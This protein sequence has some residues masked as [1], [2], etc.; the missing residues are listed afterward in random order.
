[1][2]TKRDMKKERKLRSYRFILNSTGSQ[3]LMNCVGQKGLIAGQKKFKEQNHEFVKKIIKYEATFFRQRILVYAM[4]VEET[5]KWKVKVMKIVEDY[6]RVEGIASIIMDMS[7]DGKL[8]RYMWD[9]K[10]NKSALN[11]MNKIKYCNRSKRLM[12]RFLVSY[13]KHFE[14]ETSDRYEK[15][16]HINVQY[17]CQDYDYQYFLGISESM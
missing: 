14:I 7:D 11:V 9:L 15:T 6:V 5:K 1:M 10:I 16:S 12:K 2:Q 3:H 8:N 13:K 4:R 17:L